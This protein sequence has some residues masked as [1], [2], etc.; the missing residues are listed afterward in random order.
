M[1]SIDFKLL[2]TFEIYSW[3]VLLTFYVILPQISI[4]KIDKVTWVKHCLLLLVA[5]PSSVKKWHQLDIEAN[6]IE[7]QRCL[8]WA[9]W[10][11]CQ[12]NFQFSSCFE[13]L[14]VITLRTPWWPQLHSTYHQLQVSSIYFMR[15]PWFL[16]EWQAPLCSIGTLCT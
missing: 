10:Y 6:Y 7:M 1:I 4:N 11:R 15:F 12:S 13:P 2:L 9:L 8:I 3:R 16:P 5:F 14:D